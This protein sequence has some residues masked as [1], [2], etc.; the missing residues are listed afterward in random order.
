MRLKWNWTWPALGR[1]LRWLGPSW[2]YSPLRRLVQTACFCGFVFLLFYVCWP[3]AARPA[4][5]S[6]GWMPVEVDGDSGRVT[7]ASAEPV[8]GELLALTQMYVRDD[9]VSADGV[10]D[11]S[12]SSVG[13]LGPFRVLRAS[14]QEIVL[15]PAEALDPVRRDAIQMS[16]GPWTLSETPAGEWPAHYARDLEAKESLPAESFLLLDPLVGAS[17]SLVSRVASWPLVWVAVLLGICLFIP[18]GFCGYVCPLGTLSDVFDFV[19]GRR[20]AG[21][22]KLARGRWSWVKYALLGFVLAA[23]AAGAMIAGY[24]AAIPVATRGLV[25]TIGHLQTG[26][27]RGWHQIPALGTEHWL[28]IG[29][30]ITVLG[31][32]LLASRFWC[33]Y[34]CPS[35]AMFSVANVLRLNERK[36]T[37]GCIGCGKCVRVCPFDAIQSDYT[38]R[39]LDCTFCQ[40]CGG[41]CPTT[42]ILFVPRWDRSQDWMDAEYAKRAPA[43]TLRPGPSETRRE[44]LTMAAGAAGVVLGGCAAGA[45]IGSP[46]STSTQLASSPVRP[47]G[48]VPEPHFLQLCVRCGECLRACPND[49]LQPMGLE[50]GLGPLWTPYVAADWA[51]CEASCNRC[52]HVCPTGAIRPL[53]LEEKSAARMGL[54][55]VDPQTC[56]PYADTGVCQLCVD[57]CTLAGYRAIEF[58]RVGTEVDEL[59]QPVDGSGRLA[60]VVLVDR[61]VGCGLCQT[62]CFRTNVSQKRL[63]KK[64]AINVLAGEAREDRIAAGSYIDL[65]RQ[66]AGAAEDGTHI[67][68]NNPIESDYLPDF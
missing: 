18:R 66:R 56:L 21:R 14:P 6:S 52:G 58:M 40:T 19:L 51:G 65:R 16:V 13:N 63:L 20:V 30:L 11:G 29:V 60:P 27:A 53:T 5:S 67:P 39:G 43:E 46:R 10:V 36:V 38:T 24:V 55:V 48:S 9:G 1:M 45:A 25:Y 44:F 59:G 37:H 26:L 15:E 2:H 4:A 41:A 68:A 61:C 49:A 7:V 32:G 33:K 54:A 23:A 42:A 8:A 62:R 31:L 57:E 35:G 22:M 64:S 12:N 3:Y 50:Q 17:A 28:G 34:V 47:P